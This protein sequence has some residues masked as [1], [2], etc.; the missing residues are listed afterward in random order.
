MLALESIGETYSE[1]LTFFCFHLHQIES[2]ESDPDAEVEI[3]KK[4]EVLQ[5]VIVERVYLGGSPSLV[6][7]SGF[8]SGP[9]GYAK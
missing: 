8:G 2:I 6:E 7:E 9:Q 3:A 5:Q 4:H 1:R